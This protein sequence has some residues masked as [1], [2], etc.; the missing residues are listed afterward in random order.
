MAHL[1]DVIEQH[2]SYPYR[3][4]QSNVDRLGCGVPC[5]PTSVDTPPAGG[6]F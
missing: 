6:T 5:L 4:I 3:L 2:T 1:R